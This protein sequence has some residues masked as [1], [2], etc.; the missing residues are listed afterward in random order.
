MSLANALD[1]E[2]IPFAYPIRD[3]VKKMQY[4]DSLG[5]RIKHPNYFLLKLYQLIQ[6]IDE[7]V[8]LKTGGG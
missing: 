4:I 6:Y 1:I 2:T 8:A 5:P 7:N 3:I